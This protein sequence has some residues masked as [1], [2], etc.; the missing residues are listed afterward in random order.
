VHCVVSGE[1]ERYFEIQAADLDTAEAPFDVN[2]KTVDDPHNVVPYCVNR[3][4]IRWRPVIPG[5]AEIVRMTRDEVAMQHMLPDTEL[6]KLAGVS[7]NSYF[8]LWRV[9]Q[10]FD[11]PSIMEELPQDT[12][13]EIS[14]TFDN[15]IQD[16]YVYVSRGHGNPCK[17]LSRF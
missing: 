2:I 1:F 16:K 10:W 3:Y 5:E 14:R 13:L 7:S 12:R 11:V 15:G 9:Q 4:M 17:I 6:R 8:S